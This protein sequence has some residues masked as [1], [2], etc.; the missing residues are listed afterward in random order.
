[1]GSV[2]ALTRHQ[3]ATALDL[4]LDIADAKNVD[5]LLLHI[6]LV[7]AHFAHIVLGLD[8]VDS[9]AVR[10]EIELG[11]P[12]IAII[13]SRSANTPRQNTSAIW[14]TRQPR[15]RDDN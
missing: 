11:L 14:P 1:M 4:P 12:G 10:R 3:P 7:E 9:R 2:A 15:L 8:R 6:F 5:G 13:Y